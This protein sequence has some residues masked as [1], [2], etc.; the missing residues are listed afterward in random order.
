MLRTALL[1]IA[2]LAAAAGLVHGAASGA[3]LAAALGAATMAAIVLAL[4][5]ER[6]PA[7]PKS[8]LVGKI[9]QQADLG[10][11]LAIYERQTGLFAHWYLALRCEE[12]CR[13]AKR[14]E[15]PLTLLLIEPARTSKAWDVNEQLVGW[16]RG[17]LRG[18]DLA[19]Y[20]GNGRY[21][22]LM[23]ETTPARAK[24]VSKRVLR[25]VKSC[26]AGLSCHP[27]DGATFDELCEAAKDRLAGLKSAHRKAA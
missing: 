25:E 11:K 5:L 22:V 21:V 20:L 9:A 3:P 13:R 10:R 27:D 7:S 14:Y 18:T 17:Q 23:P 26:E 12:E 1:L 19:G 6:L 15:H 16:L 2:A 4:G 24:R 8:N